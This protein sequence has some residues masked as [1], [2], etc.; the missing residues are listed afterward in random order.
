V[1]PPAAPVLAILKLGRNEIVHIVLFG[2][3]I[4]KSVHVGFLSLS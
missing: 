4:I 3:K 1:T 2:V